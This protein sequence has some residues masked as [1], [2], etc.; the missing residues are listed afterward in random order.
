[1]IGLQRGWRS[2]RGKR[3]M[4]GGIDGEER[5]GATERQGEAGLSIGGP[6]AGR[7]LS[8]TSTVCVCVCV[9]PSV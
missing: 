8:H 5:G 9:R 2:H 7:H 4:N 1:M 6:R 3:E